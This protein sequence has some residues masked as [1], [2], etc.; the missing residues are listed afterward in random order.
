MATT[1]GVDWQYRIHS[2]IIYNHSFASLDVQD[3]RH[4]ACAYICFVCL[5]CPSCHLLLICTIS[6]VRYTREGTHLLLVSKAPLKLRCWIV[7][8]PE[9][10]HGSL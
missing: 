6:T 2:A 7:F 3:R 9:S 8:F 1:L 5:C 10:V 4:D